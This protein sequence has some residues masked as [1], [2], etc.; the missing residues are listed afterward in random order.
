[1]SA[2]K[3]YR[4]VLLVILLIAE[5]VLTSVN[6]TSAALPDNPT[7][8]QAQNAAQPL[9]SDCQ[10][11]K[12]FGLSAANK[13]LLSQLQSAT[14][15]K[16]TIAC[17]E[18]TGKVRFLGTEPGAP[19]AR[20]ASLAANASPEAASRSFLGEYGAL[21]GLT[22]QARE[23]NVMREM[24]DS[25]AGS[26][27]RY[28]Q[29]Y[30]GIPVIAGEIIV[31]VD[32][33]QQV[34]SAG[35]ELVPDLNLNITP[36]LGPD[37]A[38]SQ[39]FAVVAKDYKIDPASLTATTPELWIY[40]PRLLAGYSLGSGQLVWRMVVESNGTAS[41][42]EPFQE[43]VLIN[44]A[45]GAIAL[46]FN[47]LAEAKNRTVCNKNNAPV[48]QEQDCTTP[49]RV[50]GQ[51]PTGISD[52]DLAY[53]FAGATYDFYKNNFNR[54]SLD[55]LG[56]P[57]KS[58]VK[59]CYSSQ[60]CP[61]AN[62]F[63]NGT[64]MYYGQGFAVADDVV[65]HEL[66]HGFTQY[67]SSLFYYY[68]SGAINE[69][70]SDVFGEF[71]DQSD[72]RD[73]CA[74]SG[75]DQ[76][77]LL[78]EDLPSS[79][80]SCNGQIRSM[81]DPTAFGDPDRVL[82]PNFYSDAG[83]SGGVHTN[84]G[85]NNKAAYLMTDGTANEPGGAFNGQVITGLGLTKAAHIYYE[86]ETHLLTSGSDYQD[87]YNYLQQACTNLLGQYGITATDCQ[88]VKK[89][90]DATE[91]NQI[92]SGYPEEAQICPVAGQIPTNL[93]FDNM[94]N[95]S[96]GNWSSVVTIG[97]IN[98]WSYTTGYATS[99]IRS[100]YGNDIDKA[101]DSYI[102]MNSSVTLP[103]NAL[104]HFRQ[105][106]DFESGFFSAYDGGVVE[107]STNGGGSW[108]DAGPLFASNGYNA[109]IDSFNGNPLAGRDA[110]GYVSNGYYSSRLDL[111]SLNGNSVRFRFRQGT[112]TGGGSLGWLIDDVRIYTCALP[113]T[114]TSLTTSTNP[115]YKGK[116]VTFTAT[117][118]STGGTVPTGTVT[119]NDGASTI[120]TAT[121][122]GSGIASITTSSLSA[123]THTI[124]AVYA[125]DANNQGSTS[126]TVSQ[127]ILMATPTLSLTS[128]ANP[129]Y[130]AQPVT[131]T[132]YV[133]SLGVAP[134][135]TVTFKDGSTTLGASSLNGNGRASLT[136]SN[137][138]IGAHAI[139]AVYAGDSNNLAG[140]SSP[141]SQQIVIADT[142]TTLV[143]SASPVF[144]GQSIT[145]KATV[146]NKWGGIP[147]GNI[148][149]KE[150]VTTL[151][152]PITLDGSGSATFSI[153]D[154]TAAIH[155]ITV[156]YSGD[157]NNQ[158]STSNAVSQ[159]VLATGCTGHSVTT[160]LDD[161]SCGSLR[162]TL[163]VAHAN[164]G[165]NKT[166]T[167]DVDTSAINP[168]LLDGANN[169]GRVT[170]GLGITLQRQGG[171]CPTFGPDKYIQSGV[172]STGDGITLNGATL[173][174]V[175]VSGF[176]GR[177]IV[178]FGGQAKNVMSCVRSSTQNPT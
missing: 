100:L 71:V 141:V 158:G 32:Q 168:I 53:D 21:F 169:S 127:Q 115:A 165:G 52:V 2:P 8:S 142:T 88:Q 56:L 104:M 19:V 60:P 109:T 3:I 128:S 167:I 133:S 148:T 137:L 149:I 153:S 72:G 4:S 114:T 22:D 159:Q 11:G 81:K 136:V 51:G 70:L 140:T 107:Y 82:S 59:F 134:T 154:F 162:Q 25:K 91:M 50:E 126:N 96:S 178:A 89:V 152:V 101:S 161:G 95:P 13:N 155:T 118:H 26:F 9:T 103:P 144:I 42:A 129:A 33:K 98:P 146:K 171:G 156:V 6:T 93:F 16:A 122:N 73:G 85:V 87:L 102:G 166:V 78:G 7:F 112:D 123:A 177:Q 75:A 92:P 67:T 138:A 117:V 43:F 125:G 164:L 121:L 10:T 69:S 99:G 31:Q 20:S 151:G 30:Q 37:E 175:W 163:A 170:L 36:Q 23:L 139:T 34:V 65:G 113:T 106:I 5:L 57:L 94:E 116:A 46:H 143:T 40:D 80:G 111:S 15:N 84:S 62:A 55:G 176:Q 147:T 119:F 28:Q 58:T 12:G 105:A 17:H 63:W 174:G 61:Y 38:R 131:F 77:W 110:F 54:D 74:G 83:D 90:V 14:A 47:Q 64:Q 132:A 45:T 44:A 108:T 157:S 86:L 27:V 49:V 97:A 172:G 135:G 29:V 150:G 130:A 173:N 79:G 68:Q 35:G 120:N 39:A 124:T 41:S 66:T 1:M 24:T 160:T 18:Y 76:R 145:F 48:S